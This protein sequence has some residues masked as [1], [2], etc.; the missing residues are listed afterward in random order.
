MRPP[1]VTIGLPVRNGEPFLGA[2]LESLLAQDFGD[3][4]LLVAD[5]ASSDGSAEVAAAYSR[6]DRRVRLLASHED[7]GAAWN[8]NR[9]VA[10]ASAPLFKWAAADDL[11]APGFLGC[12]V[13]GLRR[14]PDAVVATTQAV[15][16]DA[17][18]AVLVTHGPLN[19][20][21]ETQAAQRFRRA[22]LEDVFCYAVFGVVR[23]A[24]LS[25]T[26]LIGRFTGSDRVLLAELALQGR[27][28]EA[29]EPFF[30][31]RE[32]PGRSMNE[33]PD[34]RERLAWFDPARR[35]RASLPRWRLTAEFARAA[36]GAPA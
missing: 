21:T 26:R 3:F 25:R 34:D 5:N 22:V 18:G 15:E 8:F 29:D 17:A 35:G 16:I 30:L 9:C 11:C 4:E 6:C 12:C 2:T 10:A 36:V 27:F 33:H 23:R 20:I 1:A 28:L 24:A 32:H 14:H 31:H 19:R 13:E 7:R